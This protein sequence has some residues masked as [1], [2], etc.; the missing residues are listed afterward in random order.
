M[1]AST[2]PPPA[3]P[4]MHPG[5]VT[6]L[7]TAL[8]RFVVRFRWA[9]LVFWILA[10]G[11][12]GALMPSLSN[13]INGNNSAF[14]KSTEPSIRAA[15][16]A[17]PLTGAGI[18]T[19]NTTIEVIAS[20]A[21]PISAAD[22][23]ALQQ[24]VTLI[25]KVPS[26]ESVRLA[27]V[28]KDG[29]AAELLVRAAASQ[30]DIAKDKTL[31]NAIQAT[32]KQVN[33]PA[34][35]QLNLAGQIAT[36]VANQD[37]S[38]QQ[39]DQTQLF[40]VLFVI[41]L[42]L[43]VFRSPLAA[44]ITLI[45]SLFALLVSMRVVASIAS[46]G[47]L[48]ISDI[49]QILLIVLLIGAGTDYGL[50]LVFRV[51]ENMRDGLE[52]RDAVAKAVIAVGESITASAG[53]VILA[54]LTLLFATFG[55]YHD[56]G[57]PLAI[58]VFIMLLLGLTLQPALLAIFGRAAFWPIVPKPGHQKEGIWGGVAKRLVARP[59][60]TL[61][62]GIVIFGGL[63]LG[64]LGYKAG[65]FGGATTAPA[66]TSAAAGNAALTKHFPASANNPANLVFTYDTNV[67]K[68][69]AR[70]ISA[71]RSLTASK[72]FT[73]LAGPL[74][75]NGSALSTAQ[76][77]RLYSR[78]GPPQ[79]LP[80]QKPAALH[81]PVAEYNAYRADALFLSADGQTMQFEA[82][83]QAGTQDSTAALNATPAIRA[84]VA[85]AAKASGASDNGVSGEAAAVYDINK[86]ANNDLALIAPI[87]IVAIG[88]L[89]AAVLRS[90]IA[91][92]YLIISVGLSFLAALGA[93]TIVFLD[94]GSYGGITF[95][96][97]FLLFIFLLA[98]GEDYNIL[99]MTRIRE[100]ARHLPLKEAVI[101]AV[102]RSGSTV[103][104]AGIILGGTFAVFAVVGGGGGGGKGASSFTPIGFGCALG[105]LMDTF[106]VRT[107]LVP[108]TVIL[109]GRWNWW[110]SQLS[111][112]DRPGE[113]ADA[114]V[115]LNVSQ[116]R[117][118]AR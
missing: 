35:V 28:S 106:L 22:G 7:Y 117:P 36:A 89:L 53:T 107:L 78:L 4:E 100:E 48:Q 118:S 74:D 87:A 88:L 20:S 115:A 86:A 2:Q 69:P 41:A 65:G 104:T 84:A 60:I 12:T 94:F 50:F 95:V 54:L 27:G 46:A 38:N 37:Q 76:L 21:S 29:E 75:P 105:I 13:E 96:L 63:A 18:G 47:V 90:A 5:R 91:P 59:G 32:F 10:V 15:N 99:V 97:P 42:L 80:L 68:D 110:P 114:R 56:L 103:T 3:Q 16:L 113:S 45:P 44:L 30:S 101:K 81:V 66:G 39:G 33:L 24:A 31:L 58:G 25:S 77:S 108:S 62:V 8:G 43:I 55:L 6:D 57:L 111:Q 19:K 79:R 92:L 72:Q 93:A 49:T 112:A 64:A 102:A 70:I 17:A 34:G 23:K 98:L 40:S 11:V 73:G 85:R 9:I 26:V 116:D 71:Q 83:L 67:W 1:S 51:R 14:L 109:L 52:S 82:L 61:V